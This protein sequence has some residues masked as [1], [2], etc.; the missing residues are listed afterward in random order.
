MP[1]VKSINRVKPRIVR[2]D[3]PVE[4]EAALS[5][6]NAL[7]CRIYAARGVCS[8]DELELAAKGLLPPQQLDG[9]ETAVSMLEQSLHNG[10][11]L[12]IVGDYDA[13]G[14]TGTALAVRGLRAMGFSQVDYLAPDRFRFGYGLSPEIVQLAL[15]KQPVLII[16][17]DNGVSSVRGVAAAKQLVLR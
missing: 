17:V 12:M 9:V 5:D 10:E 1:Q 2:R 16:T 15:K 7:L 11:R 6:L 14:A 13:D 3:V 8:Q 4:A